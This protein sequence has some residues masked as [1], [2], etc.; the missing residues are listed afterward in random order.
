MGN[1]YAWLDRTIQFGCF[2]SRAA[3]R[4]KSETAKW[5][6]RVRSE[7]GG[8]LGETWGQSTFSGGDYSTCRGDND[9]VGFEETKEA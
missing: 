9:E 4:E 6:R 1:I 2:L 8:K 3:Q 5:V 7:K